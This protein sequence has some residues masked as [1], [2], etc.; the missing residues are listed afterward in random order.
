MVKL[1]KI[2]IVIKGLRKKNRYQNHKGQIKNMIPSIWI[3]KW[4][5]KLIKFLQKYQG[6]KLE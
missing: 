6:K 3:K 2:I 5:W 4:S 1:K